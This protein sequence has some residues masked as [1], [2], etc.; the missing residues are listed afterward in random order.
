MYYPCSENKGV[1]S[2]AVTAKM[3]CVFVFAYA[4]CW[5]SHDAAQIILFNEIEILKHIVYIVIINF[6]LF[7]YFSINK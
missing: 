5:F 2:F 4:D 3:I 1:T 7:L 6:N